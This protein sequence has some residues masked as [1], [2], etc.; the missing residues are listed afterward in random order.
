VWTEFFRPPYTCDVPRPEYDPAGAAALLEEAGWTDE[1]DDGIRECHGCLNAEEGYD[2]SMEFMTYA[3][4]G[5]ELELTQ[6]LIAEMLAE[7]GIDLRISVVEGAVMWAD[8]ESGGLEQRGEFDL[9]MWDDGYPGIDPTDHLWYYYY[10]TAA[11][12][13]WGWNVGRWIND[14]TDALIDELYYLDEEYRKDVMC[15]LADHLEENVPQIL[16][17]STFDAAGYSTRLEGVQSTVNDTVTW[18]VADWQLVE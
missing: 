11:Q 4:Y 6:Q 7:V 3:E 15:Q 2:M 10:S 1:N 5:E 8:Y 17:F 13:D 18:N 12:P 9:N 14:D 16:L